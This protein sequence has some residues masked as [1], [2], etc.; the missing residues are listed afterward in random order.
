ME[1]TGKDGKTLTAGAAPRRFLIPL[2]T[3]RKRFDAAVTAE[4]LHRILCRAYG[5]EVQRSGRDIM[6]GRDTAERLRTAATVLADSCK[7]KWGLLLQG[8]V[9][10]GKTTMIRAMQAAI[11]WLYYN[12]LLLAD[13]LRMVTAKTI[14]DRA[15]E[16]SYMDGLATCDMLAIDDLGTE[17]TETLVYGNPL[18]PVADTLLRRYERRLFTVISTNLTPRE[19]LDKYGQR[20]TDRLREM[21]TTITFDHESFRKC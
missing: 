17:P 15:A 21:C 10:N 18:T 6:C 8:N 19:R 11:N 14:T 3:S 9:G 4:V 20:I 2:P 1:I 13:G 12:N 7:T 5:M 16:V